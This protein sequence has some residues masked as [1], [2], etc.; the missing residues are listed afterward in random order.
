M[1]GKQESE[2]D[3]LGTWRDRPLGS[4]DG[5]GKEGTDRRA[6]GPRLSLLMLGGCEHGLPERGR[7]AL[8]TGPPILSSLTPRGGGSRGST[9]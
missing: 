7:V 1:R 3:S 8:S 2:H 9:L 5:C 6:E 4:G